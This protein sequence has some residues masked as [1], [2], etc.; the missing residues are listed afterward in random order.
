[1][2]NRLQFAALR[3]ADVSVPVPVFEICQERIADSLADAL[4]SR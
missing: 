2:S 1:M 4:N 3:L